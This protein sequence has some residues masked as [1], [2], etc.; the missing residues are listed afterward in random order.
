MEIPPAVCGYAA[1]GPWKR[2]GG[3]LT[4]QEIAASNCDV[5]QFSCTKL[6][7]KRT[8]TEFILVSK[9]HKLAFYRFLVNRT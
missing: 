4:G 9:S 3:W 6:P 8:K 2:S 1:A 7:N 5:H